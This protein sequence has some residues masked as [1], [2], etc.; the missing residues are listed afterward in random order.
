LYFGHSLS[1]SDS[2]SRALK[3]NLQP[4]APDYRQLV[5]VYLLSEFSP[6]CVITDIKFDIVYIHGH[7][8]PYLEP[9]SGEATLNLLPTVREDFRLEMAVLLRKAI[10]QKETV[11]LD[12]VRIKVNGVGGVVNVIVKPLIRP[13]LSKELFMVI[14][15]DVLLDDHSMT[16][17]GMAGET[18]D[19]KM[20]E[21]ECDLK[22]RE[23]HLK[24]TIEELE[25]VNQELKSSNEELQAP[26]EELQST[27][28]EMESS[29]EEL[30]SVNEELVIE[31]T[32]LQKKLEELS[33][34]Q[35]DKKI[36]W[37]PPGLD[38]LSGSSTQYST[39]SSR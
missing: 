34:A 24:L 6:A 1:E 18:N 17:G 35:D 5:D 11:R 27:N 12:R 22:A 39:V 25:T 32:E 28:E 9:P 23:E 4:Q 36:C 10:S 21:L 8:G 38:A 26:N 33:L 7:T 2:I 13:G 20:V 16:D 30:Q 14:F 19:Q 29:K 15:Q 3:K 31:N 37:Q